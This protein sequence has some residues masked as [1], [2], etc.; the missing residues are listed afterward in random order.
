M[1]S[2]RSWTWIFILRKRPPC[3]NAWERAEVPGEEG[4]GWPV[5]AYYSHLLCVDMVK[6][7][8]PGRSKWPQFPRLSMRT[9][10]GRGGGMRIKVKT[11]SQGPHSVV[12]WTSLDLCFLIRTVAITVSTLQGV[13]FK[14]DNAWVSN[15][16]QCLVHWRCLVCGGSW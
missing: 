15:A 16:T 12:T 13:K 5:T 10:Q 7:D 9:E 3:K 14:W 8:R 11:F 2:R 1:F 4:L 6:G